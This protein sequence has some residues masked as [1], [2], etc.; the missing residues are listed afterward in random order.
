MAERYRTEYLR[1][2]PREIM[3]RDVQRVPLKY[4]VNYS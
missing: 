2:L 1:D 3:S 4:A